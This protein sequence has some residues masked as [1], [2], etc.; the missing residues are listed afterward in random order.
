MP[1]DPTAPRAVA[2]AL[3]LVPPSAAPP[4]AGAG[5][6]STSTFTSGRTT[7][8][9]LADDELVVGLSSAGAAAGAVGRGVADPPT[10]VGGSAGAGVEAGLPATAWV[11]VGFGVVAD[12][13]GAST[14]TA[15]PRMPAAMARDRV[16]RINPSP[17]HLPGRKAST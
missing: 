3:G 14:I 7:P 2:A 17:R 8:P 13:G 10:A 1:P 15:A 12:A 6:A 16:L 5:E 11:G 9:D 4:G